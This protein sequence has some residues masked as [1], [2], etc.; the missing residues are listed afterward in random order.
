M[1][2]LWT[3]NR[4]SPKTDTF[5]WIVPVQ[6]R[7][8]VPCAQ[9]SCGRESALLS[10]VFGPS[11]PWSAASSC[12]RARQSAIARHHQVRPFWYAS[13]LEFLR[14]LDPKSFQYIIH[15]NSLHIPAAESGSWSAHQSAIFD[16]SLSADDERL[17]FTAS[18]DMTARVWDLQ[19]SVCLGILRGKATGHK[20]SVK[21][22]RSHPRSSG[23]SRV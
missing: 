4:I 21:V 8:C 14:C 2:V 19:R 11:L 12:R 10:G 15:A 6:Q 7:L 18:G 13:M 22:V 9:R 16:L 5:I 20:G 3:W 1:D 23:L 17:L